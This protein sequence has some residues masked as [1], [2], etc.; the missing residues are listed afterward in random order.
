MHKSLTRLL[1]FLLMAVALILVVGATMA[2]GPVAVWEQDFSVDSAGWIDDTIDPGYGLITMGVGQATFEG[3]NGSGPFSRFDHYRATWPD[4]W[5]A[6]IE[7]HLDPN[8]PTG[9]GFDYSVASSSSTGGHRRDFIFHVGVVEDYG[10][11]VGKKLL[12]NGSNNADF[13]TNPYKLVND[14][15]GNYFVVNTAGWYT[16]Q[17]VFRNNAG[18]LAVDLNLLDSGGNTLWTATRSDATDTIPAVVGGNRYGWFTHIDVTGGIEVDNHLLFVNEATVD[19]HIPTP[20]DCGT[21]TVE[22]AINDVFGIYGYQFEVAYDKTKVSATGAFVNTW[23][24]PANNGQ[25]GPSG[26]QAQ[27]NDTTGL[28]RFAYTRGNPT[29]PLSGSGVVGTVALTALPTTPGTFNIAVQ[30]VTLTDKDGYAIA[31][32]P[33]SVPVNV[34]GTT[35][36]SGRVAL[37]GRPYTPGVDISSAPEGFLV[38]LTGPYGP[39]TAVP[40]FTTGIYTIS[41]VKYDTGGTNYTLSADHS[42]YLKNEKTPLN[43]N[44]QV[45]GQN[46]R[47]LGGDTDDNGHVYIEDMTCIGGAFNTG[48][49]W[50]CSVGSPDINAD[51]FVN[52]QDLSIAGGNYNKT[53]PQPW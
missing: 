18:V 29:G 47:L 50:S 46:T 35:T 15:G 38:T 21:G 16:L 48:G 28:C 24:D 8:W 42:L 31:A 5:T 44:G 32:S 1:A 40:D 10:P 53:Q 39:Y 7:V 6:E 13:T 25:A 2:A 36:V 23:F 4:D 45:T 12:V 51:G 33:S 26:W 43:V 41:G 22:I 30:N 20:L 9:E 27:C 37:Q 52:I 14:N 34:C 19:P 11:V 17:H 3:Y 49:P